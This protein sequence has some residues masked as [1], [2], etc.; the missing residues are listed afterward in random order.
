[1]SERR[2]WAPWGLLQ[3]G[4]RLWQRAHTSP[5]TQEPA[6]ARS[7]LAAPARLQ[8]RVLPRLQAA[9]WD[10]QAR[11]PQRCC[12]RGPWQP[13]ALLLCQPGSPQLLTWAPTTGRGRQKAGTSRPQ[14]SAAGQQAAAQGVREGGGGGAVVWCTAGGKS[15]NVPHRAPGQDGTGAPTHPFA[16]ISHP[17]KMAQTGP[18]AHPPAH[19]S[20]RPPK[21]PCRPLTPTIRSS[22]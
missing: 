16:R 20:T 21:P 12:C 8:P 3:P 22:M 15:Y 7:R 4:V 13:A 10:A 17:G 11:L 18:P 5:S 6:G 1:V 14:Q 19:P 9:H 2:G